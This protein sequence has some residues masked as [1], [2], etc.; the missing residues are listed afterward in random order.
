MPTY[1]T[2]A[3][4]TAYTEG[5]AIDDAAAF[6]RLIARSERD[7]DGLLGNWVPL[8]TGLKLDPTDLAG[9]EAEALTRAVCAQVEWRLTVGE[10]ALRGVAAAP[11]LKS[12]K[13]PDF[14]KVY[15]IQDQGGQQ[16]RYGPKVRDELAPIAHLRL[17][18][19]RAMP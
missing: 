10:E 13:G 6:D 18:G 9:W 3:D 16:R 17:L 1:A 2:A 14:E 7:I 12:V 5:L 4:C 11:V 8:D 15:A 19:A